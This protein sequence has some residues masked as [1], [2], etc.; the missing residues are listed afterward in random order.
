MAFMF[1]ARPYRI[2]S[3]S[4]LEVMD[5]N[6]RK[7]IYKNDLGTKCFF[8]RYTYKIYTNVIFVSCENFFPELIL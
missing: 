2:F 7:G 4:R 1:F 6:L 8:K 3:D 5:G